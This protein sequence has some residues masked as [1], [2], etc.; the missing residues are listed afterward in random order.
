MGRRDD[1]AAGG[2]MRAH[3]FGKARLRGGVER[4]GRFVE[5]PERAICDKKPRQRDAPLLPRR[6]RADGKVGDMGEADALERGGDAHRLAAG[7]AS[8]AQHRRPEG[9][10]FAR[11]QRALQR[12]GMAEIMRLL[13]DALLVVAAFAEP[14]R[15]RRA[16]AARRSRAAGST[17]RRRWGR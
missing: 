5:Q 17:C 16:A 11:R 7:A 2:K 13:A 10:I 15:P 9:E 8:A 6:E 1:Q 3:D 14:A 12:I 4:A